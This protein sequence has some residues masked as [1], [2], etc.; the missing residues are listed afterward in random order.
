MI[1]VQRHHVCCLG[2]KVEILTDTSQALAR[3][4]NAFDTQNLSNPPC[5]HAQGARQPGPVPV[6]K[7]L[8]WRH[9]Q[10][11]QDAFAQFR[12][13]LARRLGPLACTLQQW[14]DLFELLA[15][16]VTRVLFSDSLIVEEGKDGEQALKRL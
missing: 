2:G 16:D 6:A 11:G 10:L 15:T 5:G 7:F 3:Q 9:L 4:T 14:P 1:W 13:V 8:W 12:A